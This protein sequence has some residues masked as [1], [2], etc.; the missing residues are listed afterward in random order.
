MTYALNNGD[1]NWLFF[2]PE[3][4]QPGRLICPP[5]VGGDCGIFCLA[6]A[7]LYQV[8][9]ANTEQNP[10]ND[11]LCFEFPFYFRDSLTGLSSNDFNY[12]LKD[13]MSILRKVIYDSEQAQEIANNLF[14]LFEGLGKDIFLELY[15]DMAIKLEETDTHSI[16]TFKEYLSEPMVW[17]SPDMLK[18]LSTAIFQTQIITGTGQYD[19]QSSPVF[20]KDVFQYDAQHQYIS[21]PDDEHTQSL[22]SKGLSHYEADYNTGRP[23]RLD[24]P[25]NI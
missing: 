17:L 14:E 2:T 22:L 12:L 18:S 24:T 8:E 20:E 13:T 5:Q 3:E 19:L 16:E 6:V 15:P 9:K 7:V 1:L 11:E 21:L 4:S 10:F 23:L 25:S